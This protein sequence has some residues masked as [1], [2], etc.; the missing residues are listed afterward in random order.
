M[1]ISLCLRFRDA[2]KSA[3]SPEFPV[4]WL[5]AHSPPSHLKCNEPPASKLDVI[6][7]NSIKMKKSERF[8]KKCSCVC[9][10]GA[11]FLQSGQNMIHLLHC[12]ED[13]VVDEGFAGLICNS[14]SSAFRKV[15]A[16]SM[17]LRLTSKVLG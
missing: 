13:G 6:A 3:V 14:I 8:S 15:D 12:S 7:I 16:Q 17:F 4:G 9:T 5:T 11:L 2:I 10:V 1:K